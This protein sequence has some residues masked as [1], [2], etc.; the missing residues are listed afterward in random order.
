MKLSPELTRDQLKQLTDK[1]LLCQLLAETPLN[2]PRVFL[3]ALLYTLMPCA[4]LGARLGVLGTALMAAVAAYLWLWGTPAE[5]DSFLVFWLIWSCVDWCLTRLVQLVAGIRRYV[6]VVRFIPAG[7][8]AEPDMQPGG[9]MEL[10]AAEV[11]EQ[12]IVV[13]VPES[14]VYVLLCRVDDSPAPVTMQAD[15]RACLVEHDEV[16]GLR[17]ELRAAFRLSAGCHRLR[18]SSYGEA[19]PV[20]HLQLR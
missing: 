5:L 14:G 4:V 10:P 12:E 19:A 17:T 16:P 20:L 1:E 2:L 11:H 7:E 9:H 18:V 15:S 3:L 13:K 8:D 6:R